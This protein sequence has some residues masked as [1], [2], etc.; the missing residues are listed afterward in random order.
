MRVE[1]KP[2][3]TLD[4]RPR[5]RPRKE[6]LLLNKTTSFSIIRFRVGEIASEFQGTLTVF[7]SFSPVHRHPFRPQMFSERAFAFA[8]GIE[9]PCDNMFYLY[10]VCVCDGRNRNESSIRKV[11]VR[12]GRKPARGKTGNGKTARRNLESRLDLVLRKPFS[13]LA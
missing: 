7:F 5:D 8:F 13:S 6:I 10:S 11:N 4:S 12:R 3:K 1:K 9:Y 2:P